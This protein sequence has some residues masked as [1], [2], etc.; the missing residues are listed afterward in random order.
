MTTD[1]RLN[2]AATPLILKRVAIDG[3]GELIER[4]FQLRPF[5]DKSVTEYDNWLKAEYRRQIVSLAS[6]LPAET[7]AKLVENSVRT[8]FNMSFGDGQKG[9]EL[10]GTLEGVVRL[11]HIS[12]REDAPGLTIEEVR[13]YALRG[14]NINAFLE[15]WQNANLDRARRTKNAAAAGVEPTGE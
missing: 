9:S 1:S 11:M 2:R 5:S 10:A 12:F 7:G 15:C 6:D 3:S 8:I 13:P 14:D 4:E